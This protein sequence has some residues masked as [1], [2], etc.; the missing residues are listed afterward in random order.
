VAGLRE[1]RSGSGEVFA[2]FLCARLADVLRLR[3]LRPQISLASVTAMEELDEHSEFL[4]KEELEELNKSK[5]HV[6][7]QKDNLDVYVKKWRSHD[8]FS[9]TILLHDRI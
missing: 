4:E 5:E 9:D 2:K 1:G 3:V 6:A 8:T 7:Q